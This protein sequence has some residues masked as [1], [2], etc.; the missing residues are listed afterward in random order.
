MITRIYNRDKNIQIEMEEKP[1]K[2]IAIEWM[3]WM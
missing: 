2:Q 3:N 1:T